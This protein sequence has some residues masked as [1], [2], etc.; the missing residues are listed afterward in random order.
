LVAWG[1]DSQRQW[2][3]G[4]QQD[5]IFTGL[6]MVGALALIVGL[7]LLSLHF[8]KRWRTGVSRRSPESQV[9]ILD[10]RMLAP[11]KSVAL[12]EVAGDRLLLGVGA[13]TVTLLSKIDSHPQ[14]VSAEVEEGGPGFAKTL[15]H[16]LRLRPQEDGKAVAA[17]AD[18]V[19]PP[20]R[21][22]E[23]VA[24]SDAGSGRRGD[25]E[26]KQMAMLK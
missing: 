13:E 26:K 18:P 21:R 2:A 4:E 5:L 20:E 22:V 6:K 15:L 14:P 3:V 8:L 25:V 9:Q 1:A 11:K 23:I 16:T 10:V 12:I 19:Q 7:M 17:A 24:D